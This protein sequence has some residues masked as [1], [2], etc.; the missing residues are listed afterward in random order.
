MVALQ[1]SV[2]EEHTLARHGAEL[3]WEQLHDWK[4]VNALG[5]LIGNMAVPRMSA[6]QNRQG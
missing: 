3:L 4:W 6:D 2:V 5:A 1:G